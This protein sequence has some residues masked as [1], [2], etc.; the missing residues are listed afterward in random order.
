MSIKIRFIVT[1]LFILE[2]N[3]A[4]YTLIPDDEMLLKACEGEED[5]FL[6]SIFDLSAMDFK[7][8]SDDEVIVNGYITSIVP[9]DKNDTLWAVAEVI[10]EV[11][12]QYILPAVEIRRLDLCKDIFNPVEIWYPLTSKLDKKYHVCPF[13]KGAVYGVSNWS[14]KINNINLPDSKLSG[15][16]RCILRAGA[17]GKPELNICLVFDFHLFLNKF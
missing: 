13:V 3:A 10:K 7:L 16:Y 2:T 4:L 5:H 6:T 17:H 1:L 8:I 15:G 12:G 9:L 11:R 14:A